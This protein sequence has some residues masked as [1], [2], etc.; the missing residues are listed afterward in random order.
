MRRFWSEFGQAGDKSFAG[1]VDAGEGRVSGL[2]V[3]LGE[4]RREPIRERANLGF[5]LLE[6]LIEKHAGPLGTETK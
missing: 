1:G 4:T 5:E 3:N 2:S 6:L